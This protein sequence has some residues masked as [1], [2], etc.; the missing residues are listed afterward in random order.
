MYKVSY[1]SGWHAP[2]EVLSHLIRYMARLSKADVVLS[3]S[4]SC[5]SGCWGNGI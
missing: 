2:D 3:R 1:T 5:G 4:D